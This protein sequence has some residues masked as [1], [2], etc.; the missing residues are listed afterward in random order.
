MKE[1]YELFSK[2]IAIELSKKQINK[3][4]LDKLMIQRARV[5]KNSINRIPIAIWLLNQEISK[6][7][8]I[9]TESIDQS[10]YIYK[11]L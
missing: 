10:N 3:N 9:F 4:N 6:K 2:R 5:S 8:I 7:T 11:K 1:E